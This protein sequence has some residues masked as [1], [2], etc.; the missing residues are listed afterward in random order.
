MSPGSVETNLTSNHEDA[1]WIPGPTQWLRIWHCHELWCR[2]K[3]RLGSGVAVA[4]VQAGSCSSDLTP[5]LGTS[6]CRRCGP[7]E[8]PK[9]QTLRS[10]VRVTNQIQRWEKRYQ[11]N[12]FDTSFRKA[13]QIIPWKFFGRSKKETQSLNVVIPWCSWSIGSRTPHRHRN[14]QML[15]SLIKWCNTV[16]L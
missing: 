13:E 4:V 2:S 15:K 10:Q 1:G 5:T 16:L 11:V 12:V 7:L 9:K 14:P 6:I 3:M 8:T